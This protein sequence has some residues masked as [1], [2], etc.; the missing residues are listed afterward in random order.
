[1]KKVLFTTL[2]I[3]AANAMAAEFTPD[4]LLQATQG[5]LVQFTKDNANHVQH[6]TGFK[7]WKSGE[8]AKVKVYVS[9]DGMNMEYNYACQNQN[10]QI[11]C[12]SL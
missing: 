5:S 7:T 12:T 10:N 1:M 9:H 6:M 8:D 2:M 4:Q 3:L 11:T